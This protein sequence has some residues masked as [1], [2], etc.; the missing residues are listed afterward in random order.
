MPV[1]VPTPAE[2]DAMSPMQRARARKAVARIVAQ[3]TL[4]M[5]EH[6]VAAI[7][8]IDGGEDI[9]AHAR[10]LQARMTPDPP[11]VIAER[12]RVCMT[13]LYGRSD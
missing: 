1:L 7:P 8:D 10:I 11:D 6:I 5:D 2:I 13:A 12:R 9:R 3:S 4:R